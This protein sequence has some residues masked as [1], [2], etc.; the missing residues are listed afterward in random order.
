MKQKETTYTAETRPCYRITYSD[1]DIV[2]T[3]MN[4]SLEEAATYF[5]SFPRITENYQTGKESSAD[6]IAISLISDSQKG[7]KVA[8]KVV[9]CNEKMKGE[10]FIVQREDN[11]DNPFYLLILKTAYGHFAATE[12]TSGFQL[13]AKHTK[14]EDAL[15][16][17][18][19]LLRPMNWVS[20]V[21]AVNSK[22]KVNTLPADLSAAKVIHLFSV[23]STK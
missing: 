3:E 17:A 14:K 21:E 7:L 5:K 23:R 6:A 22:E 4:A 9:S 10:L 19:M 20:V 18:L 1:G 2:Q 11:K 12:F 15:F 16:A 8:A 13:G